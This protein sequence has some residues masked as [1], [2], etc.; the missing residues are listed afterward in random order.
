M[1]IKKD[2][3]VPQINQPFRIRI[4][5]SACTSLT[6]GLENFGQDHGR[7]SWRFC[8]QQFESGKIYG[9]VSEYQQGCM[10]LSYL[11]GGRIEFGDLK[12]YLNDREICRQEL[13]KLGWNLEPLHEAHGKRTVKRSV[14]E[15]VK[16]NGQNISLGSVQDRFCLTPER[17]NMKLEDLSGERW[18]ASAA[19]GY[20][21]GKK[22]FYAPYEPSEFYYA[23]CQSA[24][25]KVFRELTDSGALVLLPVGS[26]DFMK[27][28]ADECIYIKRDYDIDGL[29]QRYQEL[30]CKGEWIRT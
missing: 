1:R 24:L 12:I 15:A 7:D 9:L 14:G 16:R 18:R 4:D 27:Y 8:S 22:I 28:I 25:L 26:D 21:S 29:R 3:D 19:V 30:F 5:T 17:E 6:E 20:V 2:L 10:Y 23:M 11:L 13:L